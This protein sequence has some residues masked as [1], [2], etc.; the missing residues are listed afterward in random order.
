VEAVVAS[1]V[2]ERLVG[3]DMKWK[4]SGGH[5]KRRRREKRKCRSEKGTDMPAERERDKE[6]APFPFFFFFLVQE[7]SKIN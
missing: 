1:L 3:R 7:V 6:E 2:A 4:L 5:C